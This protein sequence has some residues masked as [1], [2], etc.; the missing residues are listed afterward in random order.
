MLITFDGEWFRSRVSDQIWPQ[1]LGL[2]YWS[3]I[4]CLIRRLSHIFPHLS[5]I[6]THISSGRLP[7]TH[8]HQSSGSSATRHDRLPI[9][10]IGR[11]IGEVLQYGSSL[12]SLLWKRF[13]LS[14]WW[15]RATCEIATHR[16]TQR[17]KSRSDTPRARDISCLY[18]NGEEDL[19][20]YS[21]DIREFSHYVPR[22]RGR[23]FGRIIMIFTITSE[24]DLLLNTS[25]TLNRFQYLSPDICGW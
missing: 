10:W 20:L 6:H 2:Q 8:L 15:Y 14:L 12:W 16:S 25:N 7:S 21:V 5:Y 19:D 3:L 13:L 11:L 9:Q 22:A 24:F 17:G 18:I 23:R 4:Y 1:I